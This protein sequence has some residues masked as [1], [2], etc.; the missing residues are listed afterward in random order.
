MD[1]A[2]QKAD[3]KIRRVLSDKEAFRAYQ[4]REQ[5]MSD[6]TSTINFARREG[7]REGER[8][9]ILKGKRETSVTIAKE[10]KANNL[11]FDTIQ[12]CTG[13]SMEE[14]ERLQ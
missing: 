6:Y 10:M 1:T 8:K 7:I 11:P 4:M 3:A 12:K 13:L 14:I 5:A 9:G 2:I